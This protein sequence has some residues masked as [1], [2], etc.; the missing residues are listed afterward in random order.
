MDLGFPLT[1]I[2]PPLPILM[3]SKAVDAES[4]KYS[5]KPVIKP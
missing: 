5:F 1:E 2:T 3:K 4:C